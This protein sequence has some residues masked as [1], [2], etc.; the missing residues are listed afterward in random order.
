MVAATLVFLAVLLVSRAAQAQPA[1]MPFPV[2]AGVEG[3][4]SR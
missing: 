2:V 1:Q 4:H 3:T